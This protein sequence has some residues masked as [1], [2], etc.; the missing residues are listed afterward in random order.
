MPVRFVPAARRV[1][2]LR[3]STGHCLDDDEAQRDQR[4]ED[5]SDPKVYGCGMAGQRQ[6]A[7]HRAVDLVP[8]KDSHA[9]GEN[10]EQRQDDSEH[11][12]RAGDRQ[13]RDKLDYGDSRGQQTKRGA[14]PG[15]KRSFVRQ[16]EAVVRLDLGHTVVVA[17][18]LNLSKLRPS[19]PG[20]EHRGEDNKIERPTDWPPVLECR[21]FDA[22]AVFGGN[23]RHARVGLHGKDFRTGLY[24]LRRRDAR[25]GFDVECAQMTTVN[26]PKVRE[27]G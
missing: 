25:S 16:G 19:K 12:A 7:A 8:P 17:H 13:L 15:Q 14:L 21:F 22:V 26:Q 1:P 18:Q 23:P 10:C 11:V 24:Q 3:P 4:H 9:R 5:E 6:V 2:A 20:N 27:R